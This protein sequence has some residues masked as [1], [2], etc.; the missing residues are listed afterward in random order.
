[1]IGLLRLREKKWMLVW[2][3]YLGAA[4]APCVWA[5]YPGHV[6]P[7]AKENVANPRAVAVLEWTGT[8]G[9]PSAS[10]LVPVTVFDAGA[11]QDGGLYL[12]RPQPLALDSGTEYELE[13][14][15]QPSGWF[16]VYTAG[17]VRG[18]WFGFGAWKPFTTPTP[19]K[20]PPAKELPKVV[21]EENAGGGPHFKG[22][23]GPTETTDSAGTGKAGGQTSGQGSSGDGGTQGTSSQPA[24]APATEASDPERPTLRRRTEGVSAGKRNADA[25]SETAVVAGADPDR[26]HLTRGGAGDGVSG[27]SAMPAQLQG[28]PPGLQQMIAVSDATNREPQSFRYEWADPADAQRYQSQMESMAKQ[29]V[30][31]AAGSAPRAKT[32]PGGLKTGA[33]RQPTRSEAAIAPRQKRWAAG[34]GG[35][36]AAASVKLGNVQFQNYALTYGGGATLVLTADVNDA[37]AAEDAPG[38]SVTVIAQ[39]DIYGTLRVLFTAV[40]DPAHPEDTPRMRLVDAVD[41]AGDRRG[42]LLFELRG[43]HDRRFALYRVAAGRVDQVFA[44]DPLP[45]GTATP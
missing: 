35:V 16:E 4:F 41:A 10:R 37:S 12:A 27:G 13:N 6:D 29:A 39:P 43:A 40:S 5:Q 38:K 36:Q 30:A 18:D 22:K 9:K 20:L 24:G 17:E 14:A 45:V 21:K 32:D 8:A 3:G 19:K 33:I 2:M 26:P 23:S 34:R 7:K 42:D 44:T 25:P 11:L 15:G 28:T 1:M 31:K